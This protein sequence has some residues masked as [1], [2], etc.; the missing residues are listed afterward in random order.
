MRITRQVRETTTGVDY[1]AGALAVGKSAKTTADANL[2][3]VDQIELAF[4][5]IYH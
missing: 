1:V 4:A 3:D 2:G 5:P